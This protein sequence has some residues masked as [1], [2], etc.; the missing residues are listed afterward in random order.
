MS[1]SYQL[2]MTSPSDSESTVTKCGRRCSYSRACLLLSVAVA[3]LSLCLGIIIGYVSHQSVSDRPSL[4]P[5]K[6]IQDATPGITD[7][8]IALM[9]A[10]S[11]SQFHRYIMLYVQ[12]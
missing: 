11:I 2:H 4:V 6:L 5:A 9:S 8:I 7:R 1:S 3:A 12:A 10:T